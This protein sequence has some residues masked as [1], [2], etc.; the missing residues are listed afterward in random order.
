MHDLHADEVASQAG[1]DIPLAII[2]RS[3]SLR[4]VR[5]AAILATKLETGIVNEC[6][7]ELGA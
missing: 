6:A 2:S 1:M 4:I 5:L 7:M 3:I